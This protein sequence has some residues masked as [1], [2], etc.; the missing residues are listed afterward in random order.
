MF[1]RTAI[2]CSAWFD[3]PWFVV[4]AKMLVQHDAET[5]NGKAS[6]TGDCF[7]HVVISTCLEEAVRERVPSV[8]SLVRATLS[9]FGR[10]SSL[11]FLNPRRRTSVRGEREV[12]TEGAPWPL[13]QEREIR[14]ISAAQGRSMAAWWGRRSGPPHY[15]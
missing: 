12:D 8:A 13:Y 14:D 2:S 1:G 10:A 9:A 3:H 11:S 4:T 6:T 15:K 5:A 7:Y